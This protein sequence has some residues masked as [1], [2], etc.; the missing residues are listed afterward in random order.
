M[1]WALVNV[2][3]TRSTTAGQGPMSGQT[4]STTRIAA[5]ATLPPAMARLRER[6]LRSRG[7]VA[8]DAGKHREVDDEQHVAAEHALHR[9]DVVQVRAR[10]QSDDGENRPVVDELDRA[11]MQ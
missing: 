6:S 8:Q 1:M 5:D 9:V 2:N 11:Y 7:A 4:A 3:A 10:P